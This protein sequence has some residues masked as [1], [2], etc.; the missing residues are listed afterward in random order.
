MH[1]FQKLQ[2][3][4]LRFAIDL[5]LTRF[6]VASIFDGDV[7]DQ[8]WAFT[9]LLTDVIDIHASVKQFHVGGGMY[10]AWHLGG[11]VGHTP[12]RRKAI[13]NHYQHKLKDESISTKPRTFGRYL[14]RYFTPKRVQANETVLLKNNEYITDKKRMA[15]IFNKF[16]HW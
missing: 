3:G 15:N 9:K 7:D 14:E 11:D 16:Q 1:K 5:A 6:H 13:I 12:Q 10:H 2:Q 8:A 4:W